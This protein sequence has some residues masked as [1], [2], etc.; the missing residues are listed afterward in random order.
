[1]TKQNKH[2]RSVVKKPSDE[3]PDSALDKVAGGGNS[4]VQGEG[5]T[6]N[7]RYDKPQ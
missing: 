2:P 5:M 6:E 4:G 3:L 7:P 1:M